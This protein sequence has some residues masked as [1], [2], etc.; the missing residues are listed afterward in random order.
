MAIVRID[1]LGPLRVTA[2]DQD[3]EIRGRR[4]VALLARLAMA[5]GRPV[6]VDVLADAVWPDEAPADPA[7]ALQSL[8]SRLRRALGGAAAVEQAPAGYRLAVAPDAVDAVRF[9]AL[10]AQGR[11]LLAGGDPAG[12]AATLRE[13]LALWRGDPLA[14]AGEGA[15][16]EA[17]RA[18]L[19]ERHLGVLV[20]RIGADLRSAPARPRSPTS[21]AS[22]TSWRRRCR[23]VRT[24]P[25]CVCGP[26]STPAVPPR[27][28]SRT[29][30]CAARSR[31][32]S[33]RIPPAPCATSTSRRSGR[34]A[35][36]PPRRRR[37][38]VP[39]P[40]SWAATTTCSL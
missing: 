14:D 28:S 31:T 21:S 38:A 9:D 27:R 17:E 1:Y 34:T 37:C 8:V 10:A 40:A 7:N 11:H 32:P 15:D 24:S 20:D 25:P 18:A 29:R 13:A 22:S 35:P 23:C 3:V 36:P 39:S 5:P 30:P 16:I 26:C 6:P 2:G 33:A 12:A 4:L 19:R